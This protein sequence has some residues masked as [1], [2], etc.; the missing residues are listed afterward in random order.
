MTGSY[1]VCKRAIVGL[2]L[3]FGL[4]AAAATPVSESLMYAG[5]VQNALMAARSEAEADPADIA[6]QERLIDVLLTL[7]L[8]D[9][10][11]ETY[12][13]RIETAPTDPD[14]HYLLGRA[15][16][17]ATA[18]RASYERALKFEPIHA[19][20]HMGMGAIYT[21]AG[22]F[23]AAIAAYG[24]ATR[25]D[26]TLAEAW[27]GLTRAHLAKGELDQALAVSRRAMDAAPRDPDAYITVAVLDPSSARE[28]LE[29]AAK[30]APG[31][32]RVHTSLAE[33]RLAD[34][35]AKGAVESVDRALA[36]DPTDPASMR[37]KLFASAIA[38]G[39]LDLQGYRDLIAARESGGQFDA[40]VLR[41]PDAALVWAARSQHRMAAGDREGALADLEKA[42]T[43]D[44]GEAEFQ[45]AYGLLLLDQKRAQD[46]LPWLE[47][48][49]TARPWDG[50][51]GVAYGRALSAVGR[52]EQAAKAMKLF[53]ERRLY[54]SDA[55]IAYADAL[56]AAGKPEAAYQVVLAASE[57]RMDERLVV[58][59]MAAA[60]QT[61]RYGEAA[62]ILDQISVATKNPAVHDLAERLRAKA[63]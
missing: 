3:F 18:A 7:G 22:D 26:S 61:G 40:L 42:T 62:D 39:V 44:P 43:L 59:L 51:L 30:W 19:R 20:S 12:R 21:A 31:D 5:D 32:P 14:A 46:A 63:Q 55:T 10:A 60:T 6:A 15:L 57:R 1:Q 52:H 16:P 33:I 29:K 27:L 49:I 37:I 13:K 25:F 28:V 24:R 45:G 4:A 11:I 17:D 35:D 36:I 38:R 58:A 2:A 54:D 56:L 53:A 34:N 23:D 41:Y 48:A 8:Y 47:Q 50:S 9:R